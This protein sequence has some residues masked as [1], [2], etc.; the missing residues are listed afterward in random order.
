M[1]TNFKLWYLNAVRTLSWPATV[2][3]E[4]LGFETPEV[5]KG[6]LHFTISAM[7]INLE[8]QQTVNSQ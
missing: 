7:G 8:S 2:H 5:I 4:F 3:G 6:D 1:F